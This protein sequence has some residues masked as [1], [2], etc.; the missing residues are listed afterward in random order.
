MPRKFDKDMELH[1]PR[2]LTGDTEVSDAESI[3]TLKR[4]SRHQ[5]SVK[6]YLLSDVETQWADIPLIVCCYVGGI[7][8]GLSYNSWG[9][10]T[11]MQTGMSLPICPVANSNRH[12][13]P[14]RKPDL[15]RPWSGR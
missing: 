15:H 6:E 10:F 9:S 2:P 13:E 1:L 12:F 8:D 7:V 14:N 11:N 4:K 3:D 5:P